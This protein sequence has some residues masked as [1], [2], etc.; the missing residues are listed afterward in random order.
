MPAAS[1]PQPAPTLEKQ[2]LRSRM[3]AFSCCVLR[4][5]VRQTAPQ[6]SK[7]VAQSPVSG[8]RQDTAVCAA[9]ALVAVSSASL[10]ALLWGCIA[11]N[12]SAL[13]TRGRQGTEGGST[14]GPSMAAAHLLRPRWMLCMCCS[15]WCSGFKQ[16]DTQRSYWLQHLSSSEQLRPG[17]QQRNMHHN[18][19]SAW[20]PVMRQGV[21]RG[22]SELGG[23]AVV[24]VAAE[25]AGTPLAG[26]QLAGSAAAGGIVQAVARAHHALVVSNVPPAGVDGG[27]SQ[28]S[29][30]AGSDAEAGGGERP[31]AGVL[32][33]RHLG[34]P[35]LPAMVLLQ[36]AGAWCSS[37][38]RQGASQ[39]ELRP[40][41]VNGHWRATVHDRSHTW[42]AGR[43][44]QPPR[45]A[46]PA[47]TQ[48]QVPPPLSPSVAGWTRGTIK[49]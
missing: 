38:Q 9:E 12:C 3:K 46:G 11:G 23:R 39:V 40:E 37:L 42:I 13:R 36:V 27:Q 28:R 22:D 6:Y 7:G 1:A 34:A 32:L 33:P 24:A 20:L 26:V 45:R 5:V 48:L 15:G 49:E 10:G 4:A 44:L 35:H 43:W 25:A 18:K 30:G 41:M 8:L 21:D 14:S 31:A 47:A 19:A 2:C 17:K 16:H 29:R